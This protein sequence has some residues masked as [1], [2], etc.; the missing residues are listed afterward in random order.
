ME[1]HNR[2]MDIRKTR[3]EWYQTVIK[4]KSLKRLV[5]MEYEIH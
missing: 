2:K 5:T 1:E 3:N 4:T